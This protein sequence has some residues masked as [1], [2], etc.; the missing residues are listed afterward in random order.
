[1][2]VNESEARLVAYTRKT[3]LS[4]WSHS[5]IFYKKGKEFCDVMVIFGDDVVIMSDKLIKYREDVEENIS[6][7]RWYARA[8]EGSIKQLYGAYKHIKA[9]P[10]QLYSNPQATVRFYAHLPSPDKIKI[11]LIAVANGCAD[12]CGKKYNHLGLRFNNQCHG[13]ELPF[14]IGL[15]NKE[16]VHVFNEYN[17]DNIFSCLST[18]RDFIDYLNARKELLQTQNKTIEV[19]GEE[20]L[21]ACW[22][23]SQ[24]GD[25]IFHMPYN[26]FEKMKDSYIIG[27][28]HWNEYNRAENKERREKF[29][30]ESFIIDD[31]IEHIYQEFNSN[32]LIIGQDK[33]LEYHE[34]AFRLLASESR[35]GRQ[36]ISGPLLEVM[37]EDPKTF[38]ANIVESH[39]F[40]G[41]LYVWLIYPDVPPDVSDEKLL[42]IMLNQLKK[43][44]LVAQCKFKDAYVIFGACLPN[45]KSTRTDRLFIVNDGTYWTEEMQSEAIR[46]ESEEGIL[47][48]ITSTRFYSKR[49]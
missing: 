32:R 12:A 39:D 2:A 21:L 24:K 41:R 22:M 9:F 28:G 48:N 31:L 43:Y 38:W 18:T 49:V 30:R 1:M 3:F 4:M 16:F 13:D 7:A 15:P 44:L 45:S 23:L 46:L 27:P 8:I 19:Y 29:R 40:E 36:L 5:N 20:E 34:K 25:D 11:H 14:T 6:W 35:L 33:S 47:K 37:N 26:R 17:L 42:R 10:N